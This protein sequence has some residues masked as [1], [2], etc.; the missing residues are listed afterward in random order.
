MVRPTRGAGARLGS[1]ARG[2]PVGEIM[3]HVSNLD[4]MGRR[5]RRRAGALAAVAGLLVTAALV[6]YGAPTITR[7]VAFPLWYGAASGFLQAR[8]STCVMRAGR[9]ECEI[10]GRGV[11]IEDP[12]ILAQVK[13]QASQIRRRSLLIATL[14]T[15]LGLLP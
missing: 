9:G 5:R 4:E 13:R 10:Q 12:S 6:A 2:A 11:A 3:S 15:A 1:V 8:S 7:L 14:A